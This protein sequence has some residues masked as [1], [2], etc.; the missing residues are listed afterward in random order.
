MTDT[1]EETDISL[2]IEDADEVIEAEEEEEPVQTKEYVKPEEV[3]KKP[4]KF[5]KPPQKPPE[6]EPEEEEPPKKDVHPIIPALQKVRNQPRKKR[7]MTPEML[8]KLAKAREKAAETRKRNA[9]LKRNG[10]PLPKT[11]KQLRKEKLEKEI[12]DLRP[13]NNVYK[14]ENITNHFTEEDIARISAIGTKKALE[15]Y[16]EDRQAKKA[17]KRRKKEEEEAERLF[18]E[19]ISRAVEP[20]ITK[21]EIYKLSDPDFWQNAW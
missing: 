8:E 11:K 17:E 20:K 13:I 3:F 4:K 16:E 14:T 18:K 21:R 19:K 7:V 9:E 1:E 10:Q 6:P 5:K 15:K 12:H 2:H